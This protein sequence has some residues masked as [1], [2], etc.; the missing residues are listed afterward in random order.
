M[1]KSSAERRSRGR[2]P[3]ERRRPWGRLARGGGEE[4]AVIDGKTRIAG[5]GEA[6]RGE[7]D[8]SKRGCSG[9][10]QGRREDGA[11]RSARRRGA[12]RRAG[13]EQAAG[14]ERLGRRGAG[15]TGLGIDGERERAHE[16]MRAATGERKR[17]KRREEK[18]KRKARDLKKRG[19]GPK[20]EVEGPLRK[21]QKM[22]EGG[23]KLQGVGIEKDQ[24]RIRILEARWAW[25]GWATLSRLKK[26]YFLLQIKLA[27][28]FGK[29]RRTSRSNLFRQF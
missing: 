8:A 11:G 19:K 5:G 7:A 21:K 3:R 14:M 15:S 16:R 2:W 10:G 25:A 17:G 4:D 28:K 9:A 29:R 23:C 18:N 20:R 27:K 22:E 13:L 24:G 6:G 1:G 26:F 12:W